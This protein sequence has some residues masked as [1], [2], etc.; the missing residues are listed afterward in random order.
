MSDRFIRTYNILALQPGTSDRLSRMVIRTQMCVWNGFQQK[1]MADTQPDASAVVR[2]ETVTYQN[3]MLAQLHPDHEFS[4]CAIPINAT[5]AE[6]YLF[7]EYENFALDLAGGARKHGHFLTTRMAEKPGTVGQF[8]FPAEKQAMGRINY[9]SISL[10]ESKSLFSVANANIL[11]LD[12][13]ELENNRPVPGYSN[14]W[15]IGDAHGRIKQSLLEQMLL[16]IEEVESATNT[17]VQFRLAIAGSETVQGIWGKGTVAPIDDAQ[18]QGYDLIL[19][20]SCFKTYKLPN[21]SNTCPSVNL[22][23]LGEAQERA[24]K[25]GTQLWAWFPID[26]IDMDVMPETRKVLEKMVAAINSGDVYKIMELFAPRQAAE[27][28]AT[29]EFLGEFAENWFSG[30]NELWAS[31]DPDETTDDDSDAHVPT[32]SLILKNDQGRILE[33]HPYVLDSIKRSLK[34]KYTR[35]AIN[36]A[37]RFNSYM[38]MPDDSLP[39]MSFTNKHLKPGEYISFRYPIRHWGDIQLW[40]CEKKSP[41][42]DNNG[43][44]YT[45]HVTFGGTGDLNQAPY[46][47][48]GDFD[49]DYGNFG[50]ASRFP[51][52]TQRMRDWDDENSPHY[53]KRP[54]LVKAPK[55]PIQ[56][57]LKQVAL[58]SMDNLTA[59]IASQIMHAQAKGLTEEV[60]PD[61][62]GRTVLE[63]LGQALQDEVDR[64]KNDLQRDTVALEM[65]S[66]ILAKGAKR[67]VWQSDYKSPDAYL[68]RPMKVGD[69]TLDGDTISHMIRQVNQ[70]YLDVSELIPKP[71]KLGSPKFRNLFGQNPVANGLVTQKQL[72][73]A[74]VAQASYNKRLTLAINNIDKDSEDGIRKLMRDLRAQRQNL[75]EGLKARYS[76][77]EASAQLKSWAIAYWWIAHSELAGNDERH[78]MGK[79]GLPFIL[80]PDII[81]E[82][83]LQSRY[84]FS[85]YGLKYQDAPNVLTLGMIPITQPLKCVLLGTRVYSKRSQYVLDPDSRGRLVYVDAGGNPA[86]REI[87][88]TEPTY[89][90]NDG[91]RYA[92]LR[93]G[94]IVDLRSPNQS[95]VILNRP[96]QTNNDENLYL[97]SDGRIINK[98]ERPHPRK[99]KKD[100]P[101]HPTTLVKLK[102]G[103]QWVNIGITEVNNVTAIKV[104]QV[105]QADIISAKS[106]QTWSEATINVAASAVKE[107]WFVIIPVPEAQYPAPSGNYD[108]EVKLSIAT[109]YFVAAPDVPR[110]MVYCDFN[111]GHPATSIGVLPLDCQAIPMQTTV[112][113]KLKRSTN[114]NEYLFTLTGN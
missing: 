95:T 10:S 36:G 24:S 101:D 50:L 46:G 25:G 79:A 52:V 87:Q 89:V 12:D 74:R 59:L 53:R 90:D 1:W 92:A 72:D 100:I 43:V 63:V 70:Y 86:L 54:K 22:A 66:Q 77:T 23:V 99:K 40:N 26:I 91:T 82:Q 111:N 67:P 103:L 35:L 18:C 83:L 94:V 11:I 14:P 21:G 8:Y 3:I 65:V 96:L 20:Q 6:E 61:G 42:D 58:R 60:I 71:E 73:F 56:D 19:P 44:F 107:Q 88:L 48:G 29:D 62:S 106:G 80:F 7:D 15:K 76:P 81:A 114:F 68:N 69:E 34:K 113:A 45:S 5:T 105:L 110:L 93:N 78:P 37:A 32:L 108:W 98:F 51:N 4:I 31:G 33:R 75:E 2:I 55:N 84:D 102:Q 16:T 38:A 57:T 17:P 112:R 13:P 9:G 97:L 49:G 30:L 85:I 47:Q 104:G 64:Y 39:D 27:M 109:F 41:N 28:I